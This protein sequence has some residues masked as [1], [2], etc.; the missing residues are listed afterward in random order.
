MNKSTEEFESSETPSSVFLRN[1]RAKITSI[2]PTNNKPIRNSHSLGTAIQQTIGSSS[3]QAGGP[4]TIISFPKLATAGSSYPTVTLRETDSI[5]LT[6]LIAIVIG[7]SILCIIL[8]CLVINGKKRP[9]PPHFEG[10]HHMEP[11]I[12]K[13]TII[14]LDYHRRKNSTTSSL[15]PFNFLARYDSMNSLTAIYSQVNHH[16]GLHSHQSRPPSSRLSQS[17]IVEPTSSPNLH[18]LHPKIPPPPPPP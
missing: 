17:S 7:A 16:P 3:N 12:P 10:G 11:A 2:P 18:A 6:I 4:G 9:I 1:S 5:M 13:P 15:T 14:G 8:A